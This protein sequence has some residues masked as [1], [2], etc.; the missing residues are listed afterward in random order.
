ML[1]GATVGSNSLVGAT[2]MLGGRKNLSRAKLDHWR[3]RQ[4]IRDLADEAI[5]RCLRTRAT[6]VR[7][8]NR[9]ATESE[10]IDQPK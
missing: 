6:I 2:A 1:N 7:E 3:A 9:Y 10:R 4:V 5:E 8:A